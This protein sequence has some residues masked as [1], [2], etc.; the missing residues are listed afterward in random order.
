MLPTM[1][2]VDDTTQQQ[3]PCPDS[4]SP[5]CRTRIHRQLSRETRKHH[6]KPAIEEREH[7]DRDAE[8]AE[9]PASWR[10]RFTEES[11]AEDASDGDHVGGEEG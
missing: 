9:R 4:R 1:E 2:D 10:K 3:D 7:V 6:H 8:A 11:F 5:I